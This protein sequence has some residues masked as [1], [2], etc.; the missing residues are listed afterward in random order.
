VA[1][2][3]ATRRTAQVIF[4]AVVAGAVL[5]SAAVL[6]LGRGR[7]ADPSLAS[8]AYLS[9]LFAAAV[10]GATLAIRTRLQERD[11]SRARADWW[12]DHMGTAIALWALCEAAVLFGAV[13]WY[14]TGAWPALAGATLG[15]ALLLVN[16]PRFLEPR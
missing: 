7:T 9:P 11:L 6:A 5:V 4:L 14:L 10:A 15:L 3:P 16:A 2:A 12:Q 1:S 8:L 13:A